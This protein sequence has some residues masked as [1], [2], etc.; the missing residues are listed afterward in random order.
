MQCSKKGNNQQSLFVG[1]VLSPQDRGKTADLQIASATRFA[2]ESAQ[3]SLHNFM[4]K[5]IS[6]ATKEANK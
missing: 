4:L 2:G 3:F 1:Q 5:S 6:N